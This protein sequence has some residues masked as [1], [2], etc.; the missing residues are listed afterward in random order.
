MDRELYQ[1]PARQ[2]EVKLGA[3]KY[4]WMHPS[5]PKKSISEPD[6]R[7]LHRPAVKAYEDLVQ[8]R[9]TVKYPSLPCGS[10]KERIQRGRK[11]GEPRKRLKSRIELAASITAPLLH[12]YSGFGNPDNIRGLVVRPSE[13]EIQNQSVKLKTVIGYFETGEFPSEVSKSVNK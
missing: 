8:R 13:E 5:V 7:L 12:V 6:I 3:W 11:M 4:R 2:L 9:S 1:E 10:A